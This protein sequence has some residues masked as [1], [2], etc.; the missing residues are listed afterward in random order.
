MQDELTGSKGDAGFSMHIEQPSQL[1]RDRVLA[2][3]REAIVNGVYL[4]GQRLLEK[5]LCAALGVSR[6]SVRESLR[7][8]EIEQLVT[9]GPRGRPQVA[10]L[11]LDQAREIYEF[12]IVLERAAVAL[13]IARAP[14]TAFEHLRALGERFAEAL[15]TEDLT[16]LLRLKSEFYRT[17]FGEARNASMQT[18]FEQL[19][20]RIGYLRARSL[21][22]PK[23]TALRSQELGD[24]L[25]AVARRDVAAAEH[26]IEHHVRSVARGALAR[27]EADLEGRRDD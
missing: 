8:L 12:R 3:I 10:S 11:T 13:F 1:L 27:L 26:A 18:V 9:V 17:L 2:R 24:V 22:R 19:F 21:A 23:N 4:P 15:A 14:E 7:Q 25:D 6:T 20:N 16:E 5:D